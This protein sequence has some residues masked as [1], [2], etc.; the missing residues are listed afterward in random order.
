M[1]KLLT[2]GNQGANFTSYPA[3]VLLF[4]P[5][6]IVDNRSCGEFYTLASQGNLSLLTDGS[7]HRTS[8]RDNALDCLGVA[9]ASLTKEQL[10]RLGAFVCDMDP[11]TIRNSDP[12]IL[13]NLKLCPDLTTWQQ[14]ALNALLSSG[15][16]Q[17]GEPASWDEGVLQA[18]GPLAFYMNRTTWESVDKEERMVFFRNV[19]EAYD[20]Q[21]PSQRQKT[22]LLL[23][24]VGSNSASPARSKR[25]TETGCQ[26]GPITAS[27]LE[28][29]LF[30]IQYD[31]VEQFDACL[32]DEVLKAK[33]APLLEQP[34]P[35]HYLAVIKRK[36]DEIYP[37]GI[38][39]DQLK[40]LSYLSRLYSPEEISKWRVTSGDT[41]AALLSPDNG[42]WKPDQLKQ[43]I[44][45]YMELGG[46]LTGPLLSTL[47]GVNLC[48]LEAGQLGQISPDSVRQAEKLDISSC[49]QDKKDI[50]YEKARVAFAGQEET[51]A[52]Y[53][54]I[55]PYLGGAPVADL[56]KLARSQVAMDI[57]TF[58]N[59]K[60]EELK[61]L[62][63]Q[64]VR[65]L[66]AVHLLDLKDVENHP[67]V[68]MW[69][70]S[71]LQS[72]LDTLGI[73]LQGGMTG[74]SP[75]SRTEVGGTTADGPSIATPPTIPTAAATVS[76]VSTAA[77]SDANT[78][79][80]SDTSTF[81]P[82]ATDSFTTPLFKVTLAVDETSASA[83]ATNTT[84]TGMHSEAAVPTDPVMTANVTATSGDPVDGSLVPTTAVNA[85][86]TATGATSASRDISTNG[87]MLEVG[88]GVDTTTSVDPLTVSTNVTTNGIIFPS[89]ATHINTSTSVDPATVFTNVTTDGTSLPTA[90]SHINATTS[91]DT[92]VVF[93]NVTIDGI[94][95]PS[96]ATHINTSTSVDPATVFTNVTT[97]GTS[98]PTI[99]SHINATTSVDTTTVPTNVT[100]DGAI[101]PTAASQINATTLVNT[102]VASTNITTDGTLQSTAASHIDTITFVDTT[103]VSTNIT[104][105]GTSLPTIASHINTTTSVNTTMASTNVTTNGPIQPTVAPRINATTSVNT[106]VPSTDVTTARAILPT[107]AR[108]VNVTSTPNATLSHTPAL[109]INHTSTAPNLT[110]TTSS[111]WPPAP[112]VPLPNATVPVSLSTPPVTSGKIPAASSRTTVRSF[113][114]PHKT[115]ASPSPDQPHTTIVGTPE[116]GTTSRA[117]PKTKQPSHPTPNG[118]INVRPLSASASSPS[119]S[120]LLLTPSIVVGLSVLRGLF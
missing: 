66:L 78:A 109:N 59:L 4:F 25:A 85:S 42:A 23:K 48:L 40:L 50:L 88:G 21:S 64:D 102:T 118:Y 38:P 26:S 61:K 60:P 103:T 120:C 17:Y 47:G 10:Q 22:L 3:D 63:V 98:L 116:R 62:S 84:S 79:T 70:K 51:S 12:E 113:E 58:T 71:H 111:E 65:G 14:S 41:L 119:L 9:N 73:G 32:S 11:D 7:A 45:T 91:V 31:S 18:L 27:A 82:V 67:S 5:L 99:A 55:Q 86:T 46:T 37:D 24:S 28:D 54:L 104:T 89:V 115:P 34:L 8:L 52:Y 112:P 97:D 93:T 56:R 100:I 72:E 101:Q 108:I 74:P 106:T 83:E 94:I 19:A 2:R 96:V 20:S 77:I 44:S 16:T 81:P 43:L 69:I 90:A 76:A 1:A 30:V 13:E 29:P 87:T 36:L 35:D 68:A 107:I 57:D 110:A 114:T 105:D 80:F 75:T 6:G 49:S 117:P 95:F 15:K 92:T 33:L 53:P 39:D